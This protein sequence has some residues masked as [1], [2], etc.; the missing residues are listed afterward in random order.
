MA[1]EILHVDVGSVARIALVLGALNGLILAL[2]TI[3]YW[4]DTNR[5]ITGVEMG[6][7]MFVIGILISIAGAAVTTTVIAVVFAFVYNAVARSI[8]GI[9]VTLS[10]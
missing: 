10:R 2:P 3:W 5:W 9:E 1:T 8:G 4:I 7:G 6:P